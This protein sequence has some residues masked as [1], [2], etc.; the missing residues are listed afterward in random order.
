VRRIGIPV[1]GVPIGLE[2]LK[3][4]LERVG[5]SERKVFISNIS[6]TPRFEEGVRDMLIDALLELS[7]HSKVVS[8]SLDGTT[9]SVGILTL[10]GLD[11][12]T[13]QALLREFQRSKGGIRTSL[14]IHTLFS[15][16]FRSF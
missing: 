3:S 7:F 8:P 16:I 14:E 2:E 13:V 12:Y 11:L 10:E 4:Q 15:E 5:P 9:T 6:M 1:T